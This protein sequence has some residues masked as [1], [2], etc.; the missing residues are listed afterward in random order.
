MGELSLDEMVVSTAEN[1]SAKNLAALLAAIKQVGGIAADALK[2]LLERLDEENLDPSQAQFLMELASIP[3]GDSAEFRL[4]LSAAV[5]VMLP[6]YLDRAPILRALGLRDNGAP[7]NHIIGRYRKLNVLKN[8]SIVYLNS[9]ARW[10]VLGAIDNI[11]GTIT[12]TPLGHGGTAAATPLELI[13]VSGMLF[14]PNLDTLKLADKTNRAKLSGTEFR[15]IATKRALLP[16]SEQ[17]LEQLAKGGVASSLSE[18]EFAKWY[19]STPAETAVRAKRRACDGR[20]LQE[21]IT[22]LSEE[23]EDKKLSDEEAEKF[24]GF[25]ARMR[26]EVAQMEPKKLAAALSGICKQATQEQMKKIF[27][28]LRQK[29]GFFPEDPLRCALN[30]LAVWSELAAKD[31]NNLANFAKQEFGADYLAKAAMRL[32]LK[33]L[34]AFG[35]VTPIE[36]LDTLLKRQHSFSSDLG[37]WIWKNRKKGTKDLLN[38]LTINGIIRALSQENLPKAWTAGTRELRMLLLDNADFQKFIIDDQNDPLQVAAALQ[39]ALFLSGGE[40]QSLIVKLS[41]YSDV[42]REHIESGAGEKILRAGS[43]KKET[44]TSTTE[45]LHLT[46]KKSHQALVQ[47]LS[48]IINIYQPENRE[49]LAAARAHGDFR[50]NAEFDA[51]KERRNYLSRRQHELERE[52]AQ[53]QPLDMRTVSVKDTAV[54]GCELTL[55][56]ESG[57]EEAQY[58]LGA[59]D[60]NPDKHYLSYKTRLGEILL[61]HK[62]GDSVEAPG[63]R[64]LTITALKSLP[65]TVLADLD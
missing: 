39:G 5:K 15:E 2:L 19:A 45:D 8:G 7:L 23:P 56:D 65:E 10:G 40:R 52:L 21:I 62:V 49:A 24:A 36:S 42:L 27:E 38:H 47:E 26:T 4:L 58:L 22:L 57:K 9:S 55:K 13:L 60:G 12:L 59:F 6:P 25:F 61:G 3:V 53:L 54:I 50:E 48:D 29:T 14:S 17:Q 34:N 30:S 41:R 33:A 44:E 16:L 46:S 37:A 31:L 11:A 35:A 63:N 64:K 43:G 20:S 18:G 1:P 32:P 51:A 28:P